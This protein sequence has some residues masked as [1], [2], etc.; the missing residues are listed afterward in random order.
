MGFWP[1]RKKRIILK[2]EITIFGMELHTRDSGAVEV[3][4]HNFQRQFP[5]IA[6]KVV[7]HHAESPLDLVVELGNGERYIFDDEMQSIRQLPATPDLDE[8]SFKKEFRVRLRKLMDRNG[9]S[10]AELADRT[11]IH[12]VTISR[13]LTGRSIP[14]FYAIDKIAKALGCSADAFRYI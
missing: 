4:W 9:I 11:G 13:Y 10:Q 7:H 1:K 14:S 8:L 3:M 12:E 2:G 5:Y 6:A